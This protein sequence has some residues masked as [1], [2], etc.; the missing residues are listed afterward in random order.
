MESQKIFLIL[1]FALITLIYEASSLQCFQCSGCSDLEDALERTCKDGENF[2]TKIV[3]DGVIS[4]GCKRNNHGNP[5]GCQEADGVTNCVCSTDLCNSAI[6]N[7][8]TSSMQLV[9]FALCTVWTSIALT[10]LAA[11]G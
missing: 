1:A 3:L 10:R 8:A 11:Y 4:R 5:V 9:A 7:P 6:K 2:C